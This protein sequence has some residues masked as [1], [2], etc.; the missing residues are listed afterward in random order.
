LFFGFFS[1]KNLLFEDR[2]GKVFEA[3][4]KAQASNYSRM[5]IVRH[6][7]GFPSVCFMHPE[8]KPNKRR[9]QNERYFNETT[10]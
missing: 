9:K 8:D 4:A 6:G 2:Y 7:A 10:A 3:C 1:K 5:F